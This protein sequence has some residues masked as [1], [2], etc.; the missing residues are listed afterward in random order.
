[1]SSNIDTAISGEVERLRTERK[2]KLI[3]DKETGSAAEFAPAGVY[4]FTYSPAAEGLPIFNKQTFQIFEVHKLEDQTVHLIGFMTEEHAEAFR[5]ANTA[6]ELKLYPQ[7]YEQAKRLV[8]I[9]RDRIVR[10]KPP[11]RENGNWMGLIVSSR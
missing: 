1:M 7:P 5:T 10:A 11:S 3:T 4:G 9:P 6:T 2:L 8:S